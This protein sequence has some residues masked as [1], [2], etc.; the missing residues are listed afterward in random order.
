MS[1]WGG[2][3]AARLTRLM[4]ATYGPVCHLCGEPIDLARRWPDRDSATA[5]HLVP[6]SRG[7]SDDLANLRPAHLRCNSSRHADRL[8]S[9]RKPI[10]ERAFFDGG[11]AGSPAPPLPFPP[12]P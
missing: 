12:E 6:R 2:R 9:V 3:K 5:D 10:D 4:L 8:D 11:H 7:G 1:R